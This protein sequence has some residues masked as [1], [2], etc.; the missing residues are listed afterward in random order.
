M[1]KHASVAL[2]AAITVLAAGCGSSPKKNAT[3]PI[4]AIAPDSGT[5]MSFTVS[6]ATPGEFHR[7]L[8]PLV[9]D[10]EAQATFWES[11]AASPQ[12]WNARAKSR[13]I[14]DG[15]FVLTDFRGTMFGQPFEGVSLLGFDNAKQRYVS[16]WADTSSTALLPI[17]EGTCSRDGKVFT[18]TRRKQDPKNGTWTTERD[19]TTVFSDDEHTFEMFVQ[20]EGGS[21]FKSFEIVYTRV[22]G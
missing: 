8:D 4:D 20:P 2:A 1:S 13:W 10:F 19:V 15:R 14:L 16:T 22:Q 18:T 17:A 21:E 9:G 7:H 6:P 3:P 12:S 11:A 5:S